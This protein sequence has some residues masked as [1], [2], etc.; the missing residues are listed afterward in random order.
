MFKIIWKRIKKT[1]LQISESRLLV[2]ILVFCFLYAILINKLF[3]LQIVKGEYYM[4]NY[5][6]QIRK[7]RNLQGTRGAIYD[8]NGELLAYNELA[9]SVTFEDNLSG[10]VD[11]NETL[12]RI[13][14]QVIQ[15]LPTSM[16]CGPST[17]L[18]RSRKTRRR[19]I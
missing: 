11:R 4:E 9:Y 5:K 3:N 10:A 16:V 1:V 6:L 18:R 13:M 7:E 8:R 17:S 19:R 12:N 14:D 2:L 15:M